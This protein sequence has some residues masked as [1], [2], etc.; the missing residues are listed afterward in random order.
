[1]VEIGA[2]PLAK[3]SSPWK[4][5][6]NLLVLFGLVGIFAWQIKKS[7]PEIVSYPWHH[8]RWELAGAAFAILLLCS[9]FEI[10]IWNRSLSW[11]TESLPFQQVTPVFI[12]SN[13]AR[14]I[15]GKVASLVLRAALA[16]EFNRPP[17]PVLAASALELALRTASA[18]LIFIVTLPTWGHSVQSDAG[19]LL[20]TAVVIIAVVIVCAHP[21]IMIP[22][23]NWGLKKIKQPPVERTVRYR[24]VLGLLGAET[25]RWLL[26]GLAYVL[27]ACAVYPP[28]KHAVVAL[29]GV[30]NASWAAGFIGMTPGGMG[31]AEWVQKTVL[32]SSLHFQ[33]AVSLI[34]PVLMRLWSLVAEGLWALAAWLLYSRKF[35]ASAVIEQTATVEQ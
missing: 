16:V 20:K 32:G 31:W 33:I 27:L 35:P 14:Y 10:L 28:A 19:S 1:M 5:L 34:L 4:L 6:L 15:P 7:W 11:F 17:V 25:V 13:L 21:R 12:W 23:L 8:L 29:I 26:Y 24:D 3:K 9:L 2:Q 30:A 22:V 18:L